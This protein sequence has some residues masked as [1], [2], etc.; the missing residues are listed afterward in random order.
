MTNIKARAAV[1]RNGEKS[2]RD[3][4]P[5][6][7]NEWS[8][9]RAKES[10]DLP[11]SAL[12]K[13]NVLT[14]HH[15]TGASSRARDTSFGSISGLRLD[16]IEDNPK[17]VIETWM[18]IRNEL[19]PRILDA[20]PI[21]AVELFQS[22]L[23]GPATQ[24]FDEIINNVATKLYEHVINPEFN[25]RIC[26]MSEN[27]IR[28][29][30][31][32]SEEGTP[33][34]KNKIAAYRR[35]TSEN[36]ERKAARASLPGVADYNYNPTPEKFTPPPR[37]PEA[38]KFIEWNNFGITALNPMAW[39]RLHNHGWQYGEQF[40]NRVFA[41][42]Q[43]LAFKSFGL[44]CGQDQIAYLTEDLQMDPNHQLKN[45]L[46]LVQA[47]AEAQAY[48]PTPGSRAQNHAT[49][50]EV[51]KVLTDDRKSQIVWNACYELFKDELV[52]LNVHRR[53]D[54][55]NYEDLCEKF[56]L[57]E[58]HRKAK[59]EGKTP[60]TTS[61][62]TGGK[63][64]KNN[65]NRKENE[66]SSSTTGNVKCGYCGRDGHLGIHC[67]KNPNSSN[68]R[69]GSK[70]NTDGNKNPNNGGQSGTKRNRNGKPKL[71]FAEWKK[72]QDEQAAYDQY[73]IE[74]D[75]EIVEN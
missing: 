63:S 27:E 54:L 15:G 46:R 61:Q 37:K 25:N 62:T 74:D 11:K 51:G 26:N 68:Y 6:R 73:L 75:D 12:I 45:F 66:R 50:S 9:T 30:T 8:S 19:L 4:V 70:A 23:T 44:Q 22:H 16:R 13:F 29:A 40:C 64:N 1:L 69:G 17:P 56:I 34:S 7:F 42:I 39:L 43:Q 71:S 60:K 35:W 21:T 58:Q 53:D 31:K 3:N 48:Y 32:T 38:G 5:I 28:I 41:K 14:H 57:A 36:E 20:D 55:Q 52:N 18:S 2:L 72:Q 65:K 47:H 49:A 10:K 24:E 59:L 33:L 67:H